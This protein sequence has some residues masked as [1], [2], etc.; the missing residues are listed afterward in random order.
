M[1]QFGS[2][3]DMIFCCTLHSKA[4]IIMLYSDHIMARRKVSSIC[5]GA[6]RRNYLHLPPKITEANKAALDKL[7]GVI[8]NGRPTESELVPRLVD[9]RR[10]TRYTIDWLPFLSWFVGDSTNISFFT[11]DPLPSHLWQPKRS[12]FTFQRGLGRQFQAY[13][14]WNKTSF[15]FSTFCRYCKY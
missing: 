12:W 8:T 3:G 9:L 5:V 7:I 2:N 6:G 11:F 1:W 13:V 10:Q 14:Q 4:K 15:G